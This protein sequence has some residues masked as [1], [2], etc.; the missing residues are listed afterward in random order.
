VAHPNLNLAASVGRDKFLRL[1]SYDRFL[2]SGVNANSNSLI[3]TI[4]LSHPSRSCDFSPNGKYLAVGYE[5][6]VFEVF[7]IHDNSGTFLQLECLKMFDLNRPT[8]AV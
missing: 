5:K 8:A 4:E 1:Y 3:N 6:G 7:Q 2:S